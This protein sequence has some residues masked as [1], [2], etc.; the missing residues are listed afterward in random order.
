[1]LA[2]RNDH[3]VAEVTRLLEPFELGVVALPDGLVL[4]AE[5]GDT[6]AANALTKARAGARGLGRAVIADD[7]GIEAQALG[8]R[9]GIR[10]ARYA[11]AGATDAQNLRKL[12]AEVPAGS[13][14]RYVCALAFVDGD[15]E[16]VSLGA[17][18]GRMTAS[19]RGS[20]GFGYDPIFLPDAHPDLTMA[21]LED[22]E[23][24]A[25]S[26]RGN[27]LR[28]FAAWFLARGQGRGRG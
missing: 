22:A 27:A 26:H 23:K 21:E 12:I 9:P 15:A 7:S 13:A 28:A 16:H 24:D 8:G 5:D 18:A 11:G 20:N 17:C 19:A 1:M 3:K 4:P 14:L 25:I 6:Y 10:S 2:T